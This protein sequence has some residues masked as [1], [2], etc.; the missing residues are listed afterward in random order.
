MSPQ[1]HTEGKDS[2]RRVVHITTVHPWWDNRI[3]EKMVQGLLERGWEVT[4]IA[5]G[6]PTR[7]PPSASAARYIL[8]EPGLA[9]TARLKRD[10]RSFVE[11]LRADAELVHFHDPEFLPFAI[12]LS[13]LGKS[14]IYDVH[15]DNYLALQQKG[16]GHRYLRKLIA[17]TVAGIEK[18][19]TRFMKIVIAE[20]AYS[21]R[22]PS[23][24][25]ILNYPATMDLAGE[26]T[27]PFTPATQDTSFGGRRRLLYTGVVTE[28]RGAFNHIKL[29]TRLPEYELHIVGSCSDE[30][31]SS[32]LREA[33]SSASRLHFCVS[34]CGIPFSEIRRYYK[35]GNWEWGLA[36]FPRT[37]H[38]YE[39]ELT[40]FF[41]FMYYRIPILFSNF[42]VWTGLIGDRGV[43][44]DD[45]DLAAVAHSV[46]ANRDRFD[47]YRSIPVGPIPGLTWESQLDRLIQLYESLV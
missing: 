20:K 42:P 34:E 32:L 41:E 10:L 22:F 37:P 40:K 3:F 2:A 19:A 30:L 13:L 38:Y 27:T 1:H 16:G 5:P 29:L 36:V 24:L 45:S 25:P 11:S 7:N 39:K 28:D 17:L 6:N 31:K 9:W 15:E 33:G 12:V 4:Y 18:V 35:E 44:V 46:V 47:L 14:V 26:T 8:L 43:A 21:A 23:G